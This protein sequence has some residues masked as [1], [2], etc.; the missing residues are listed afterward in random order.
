MYYLN[1]SLTLF[2]SGCL[3]YRAYFFN[4]NITKL[5]IGHLHFKL[6]K[7]QALFTERLSNITTI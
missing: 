4:L 1:I 6:I 7:V 3:L 2:D 5:K